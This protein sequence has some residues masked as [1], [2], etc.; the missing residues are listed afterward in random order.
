MPRVAVLA[1]SISESQTTKTGVDDVYV[2]FKLQKIWIGFS[3][4]IDDY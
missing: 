3:N 2:S 4:F 1:V